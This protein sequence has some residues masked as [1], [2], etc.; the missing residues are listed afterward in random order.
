VYPRIKEPAMTS[1]SVLCLAIALATP[2]ASALELALPDLNLAQAATPTTSNARPASLRE[3]SVSFG[4][5]GAPLRCAFFASQRRLEG[6]RGTVIAFGPRLSYVHKNL[7]TFA[8]DWQHETRLRD[9]SSDNRLLLHASLPLDRLWA[10]SR[11]PL[12]LVRLR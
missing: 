12:S 1:L 3:R 8:L 9:F 4:S 10:Q 11:K 6:H 5:P 2:A 7:V